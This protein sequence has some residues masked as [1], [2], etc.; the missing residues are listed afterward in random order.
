MLKQSFEEYR[1][2]NYSP[3]YIDPAAL[4][5]GTIVIDEG[6][7]EQRLMYARLQLTAGAAPVSLSLIRRIQFCC[8]T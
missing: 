7:D 2:G 3:R 6:D 5:P 4:E 1:S 8:R